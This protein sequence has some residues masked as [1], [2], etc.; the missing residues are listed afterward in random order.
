MQRVRKYLIIGSIPVLFIAAIVI[1]LRLVPL[2]SFRAPLEKAVSHGLGRGVHIAGGLHAS[3]YPEI[4]LTAGDVSIDNVPGGI[5]KEFAHVGTLAV[6]AK[7]LP[8]LS[9]EIDITRLALEDP[10]IHLEVDGS[11]NPNWNLA[12]TKS[13]SSTS[14]PPQ[15]SISGLKIDGAEISYFDARTGK[16]KALRGVAASLSLASIGQPAAL[17]VD[18]LYND[19]KFTVTG[20]I[21]SP[22]SYTQ[23]KPTKLVLDVYSRL[24]RLHFDGTV[25]GATQSSGMVQMSGPSLRQLVQGAGTAAPGTSGLGA[26]S[27]AGG[28]SSKDRVYALTNAKLSLDDMKGNLDLAVDMTGTLPLLKGKI[29][30]DRLDAGAYM[31]GKEAEKTRGWNTKPL[32]LDGLKLANADLAVS[33]ERFGLGNFVMTHGAM[34]VGLQDAKLT[35]DLTQASL[36][37]GNVTGRVTA[38]ASG[39]VPAFTIK[40][41]MKSVAMKALLQSAMKVGR[42]EGTGF[43]TM[44][45]AGHGA[46]QQAIV[47]S[48]SGTSSVTMKN[49]ALHGVDLGAV[50]RTIQGALSGALGAATGEKASTDFAEAGGKFTIQGGVMH[51]DDFHLLSPFM[52]VTGAGDINLAPRTLNFRIEPKLVLASTGQGGSSNALGIGVPFQVS[53]PWDRLSY[54][55]D[56]LKAVTGVIANGLKGGAGGVT[57]LLGALGNKKSGSQQQ[58]GLNLNGLFGH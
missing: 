52:R 16:H 12:T 21:D 2:D 4:G 57:S 39:A 8:L 9:G 15:L 49:G 19:E 36:F 38:D 18:G 55:P 34:H 27:L 45:V 42:I 44:D 47:S 48:L 11:G 54:R 31:V 41:D 46:N 37:N 6:G 14:A 43:L 29:A 25:I 10:S 56:L 20:S 3:L 58:S 24:L 33:V 23:K 7:L 35:A 26:F 51:N 17:N 53:G 50:A 13:S 1:V 22:Q 32:S 40:A 5:D 30:L 28:V